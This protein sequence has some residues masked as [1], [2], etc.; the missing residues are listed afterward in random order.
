MKEDSGKY[1]LYLG[2]KHVTISH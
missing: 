1:R 2:R